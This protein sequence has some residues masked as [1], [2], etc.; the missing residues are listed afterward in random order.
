MQGTNSKIKSSVDLEF[1]SLHELIKYFE[2][3]LPILEIESLIREFGQLFIF[4]GAETEENGRLLFIE[5]CRQGLQGS[6]LIERER[7]EARKA[8]IR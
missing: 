5:R 7:L 8:G 3:R 4:R 2:N 1:Q 6:Q